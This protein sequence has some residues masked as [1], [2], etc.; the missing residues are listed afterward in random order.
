LA[1]SGA[2]TSTAESGVKLDDAVAACVLGT[3]M[4]EPG[5]NCVLPANL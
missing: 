4:P 2:W 5:A 1:D 3:P